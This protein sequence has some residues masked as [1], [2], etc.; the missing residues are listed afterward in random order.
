MK[1]S[2]LWDQLYIYPPPTAPAKSVGAITGEIAKQNKA[3]DSKDN[4]MRR[5][6]NL[7]LLQHAFSA[8][9]TV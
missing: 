3:K 2:R 6:F 1:L 5:M 7:Q 4:L 8:V 9:E